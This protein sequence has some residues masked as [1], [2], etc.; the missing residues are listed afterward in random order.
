[1][2]VSYHL[3]MYEINHHFKLIESAQPYFR[4]DFT[5]K[6]TLLLLFLGF[7]V[8]FIAMNLTFEK[9]YK[10]KASVPCGYRVQ[11]RLCLG[12]DCSSF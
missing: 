2:C 4:I 9:Q 10:I 12:I 3:Q 5:I 6:D 7:G 11:C 8:H 1:M